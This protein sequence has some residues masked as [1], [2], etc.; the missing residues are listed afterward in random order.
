MNIIT[1]CAC[2][3]PVTAY[4]HEDHDRLVA[5][6]KRP[7]III[8]AG[9]AY[10]W[11]SPREKDPVA[12]YFFSMGYQAFL[13]DYS[14]GERAGRLRPL[15]ELA[16]AV[17]IVRDKAEGWH[18]EK[19][20]IAV[21]G[22]SAGGHLAASLGT[23]WHRAELG[24]SKDCRPDALILCYPVISTGEYA[25]QE[26]VEHVTGKDPALVELLSLENQVTEN[27]PPCFIWHCVGDESVP[28][29][30]TIL[31]TSAMQRAGTDYECHLFA[32]GAHGISMCTQEVEALYPAAAAWKEL[33]K[34]WL[35]SKFQFKP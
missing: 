14:V 22:F 25:H 4:I 16:E 12:L 30:N 32:G 18:I 34:T 20:H 11:L 28:V 5:H 3:A 26:S 15:K 29:E 27:L 7:A 2:D 1:F 17:A 13:V 8:C 10:R 19:D 23:L 33:C 21:L 24:L 9:G 6:K 31:F 35:N